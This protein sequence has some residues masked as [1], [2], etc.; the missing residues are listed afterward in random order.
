[1][2]HSGEVR[3]NKKSRARRSAE[4]EPS[5][6]RQA[7]V[8]KGL[9]RSQLAEMAGVHPNSIKNLENGTTREVT[10]ENAA[11][12]AE[13]LET[14]VEALGLRVRSASL[15]PSIRLRQL[16]PEQR[17]LVNDILS[18]SEAQYAKLRAALERIRAREGKKR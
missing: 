3:Q 12:I 13:A 1:M 8:R 4:P 6:L 15:A 11:A 7:R 5:R 10:A 2:L 18:L 14:S 9:S 16:S 17:D